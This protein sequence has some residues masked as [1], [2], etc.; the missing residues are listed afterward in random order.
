MR[1]E[2]GRIGLGI[3]IENVEEGKACEVSVDMSK[4]AAGRSP[5]QPL[6]QLKVESEHLTVTYRC[7]DAR[8][9]ANA[10][11]YLAPRERDSVISVEFPK[12]LDADWAEPFEIIVG[13]DSRD[14]P[15]TV[16]IYSPSSA[17]PFRYSMPAED[18][19]LTVQISYEDCFFEYDQPM[20]E[21]AYIQFERRSANE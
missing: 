15:S 3:W 17:E 5:A 8:S 13:W 2:A 7:C 14:E 21:S 10:E 18:F 12:T 20:K 6:H 16:V 1:L 9:P 19:Y 11:S 4:V